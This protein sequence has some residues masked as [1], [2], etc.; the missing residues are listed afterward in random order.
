M[1][2]DE[3]IQ[4]YRVRLDEIDAA[5]NELM[6]DGQSLSISGAHSVT[7]VKLDE[8]RREKRRLTALLQRLLTGSGRPRV[9]EWPSYE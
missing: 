2:S 9:Q 8:L 3:L 7:R 1:A 5:I 6:L 4:K